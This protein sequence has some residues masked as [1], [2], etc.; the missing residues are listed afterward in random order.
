MARSVDSKASSCVWNSWPVR[1]AAISLLVMGLAAWFSWQTSR[2]KPADVVDQLRSAVPEGMSQVSPP[3]ALPPGTAAVPTVAR[4]HPL[5]PK[6][7]HRTSPKPA[8]QANRS[9]STVRQSNPSEPAVEGYAAVDQT[10]IATEFLPIR[11]EDP[12]SSSVEGGQLVRVQLPRTTLL[13][14][15]FPM[16]QERYSEP[17]K[18]DVLLGEDGT[19]RAIRFVH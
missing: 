11:Y 14:F 8:V 7:G 4:A 13:S 5:K 19:A 18:A 12:A 6:T 1:I 10:E 15:G 3:K 17:I 2:R 9:Q 16:S